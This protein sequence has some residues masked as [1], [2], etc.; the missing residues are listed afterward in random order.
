MPSIVVLGAR[1]LGGAILGHHLN[2]G[3]RGAAVARS[4]ET[5]E[6]VRAAGG[7][8]LAADA[9]DPDALR[10]ALEQ[11]RAEFG[12]I[13]VIV[14][15]VS[16]ARPTRSRPVRRRRAGEA[17]RR[18]LPRLDRRGRRAGLRVPLRGR[19]RGRGHADPGHRRQRAARDARPR[20][21]GGGRGRDARA[22]PRRGAGAARRRRPRRAADRRRDDRLAQDRA[23]SSPARPTTRPPTRPRSRA[24]S[25]TSRARAPR[26]LHARAGGH[27]GGRPL[28]SVSASATGRPTISNA[29]ST[30]DSANSRWIAA[31]PAHQQQPVT[32]T[33]R[34]P[35]RGQ[36][37]RQPA[38]VEERAAR[39]GR[40]RR[41]TGRASSTRR[42][43]SSKVYACAR[44]SSPRSAIR[45]APRVQLL[46]HQAEARHASPLAREDVPK[47]TIPPFARF[48]NPTRVRFARMAKRLRPHLR[49]RAR[50]G[51]VGRVLRGARLR[52]ARQ[53][54]V[55]DR[56]QH[57]HG[58]AGRRRHARADGQH[59]PRGAVRP[60]RRLQPHR[61]HG[62]RPR[63]AAGRAGRRSASSRRSRRSRRAGGGDRA[64]L[65]RR[66]IRTATGSS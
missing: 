26:A 33:A 32:G 22:R 6:T 25:S 57:L 65:L 54:P 64:D 12:R 60:R 59:R 63:R 13:D 37:P 5:L 61:A 14:N 48:R 1:N 11:A 20:A 39:A 40:A 58:P 17:D 50:P 31:G 30:A 46:D 23:S 15:A 29:S 53:A 56:V 49:P 62:R 9:S 34:A 28:G 18:G 45:T 38:R 2:N 43:S 4:P 52:A 3:W 16:A 8:P 51:Q 27:A 41:T 21:V 42:S 35:A 55:R 36:Q 10:A 7:L 66:R 24:P 19:A 47:L 44:S